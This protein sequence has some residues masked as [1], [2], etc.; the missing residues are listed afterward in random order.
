[1]TD[2]LGLLLIVAITAANTGDREAATGL[3]QRLCR[4]HRD[5]TLVW[6]DDGYTGSLVDWC[7]RLALTL[8]IVKRTAE[9]ASWVPDTRCLSGTQKPRRNL[10]AAAR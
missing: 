10:S 7:R 3:L 4:V 2:C 5:I 8:E 9:P 1:M 6:A